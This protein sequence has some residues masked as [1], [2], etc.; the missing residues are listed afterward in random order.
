L[1]QKKSFEVQPFKEIRSGFQ[2]ADLRITGH[3]IDTATGEGLSAVLELVAHRD[4][5]YPLLLD[6]DGHIAIDHRLPDPH[7]PVNTPFLATHRG[8][9]EMLK[10]TFRKNPQII[11]A[12]QIRV[13]GGKSVNL[14]DQAGTF[15]QTVADF[16]SFGDQ[17]QD[18]LIQANQARIDIVKP[19]LLNLGLIDSQTK[20]INFQKHFR[21]YG[22][23]S[24]NEGHVKALTVAD[25]ERR[26]QNLA[27]CLKTYNLVNRYLKQVIEKGGSDFIMAQL[28]SY[29]AKD[30]SRAFDFVQFWNYLIAEGTY[31]V[32]SMSGM[33][34][35]ST[36]KGQKFQKF[37][38]DLPY[39]M[40]EFN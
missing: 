40:P 37:I 38:S 34:D 26:C 25:F 20:I 2:N 11:F 3:I 13:V 10:E 16:K 21:Y 1:F 15:Y 36:E 14:I 35:P 32:M 23:E 39:F 9:F 8:L 22:M 30:I 33:M 17:A 27:G 4:G 18:Y 28:K 19:F 31:D 5:T 6:K 29:M 12:G 24:P 7:V